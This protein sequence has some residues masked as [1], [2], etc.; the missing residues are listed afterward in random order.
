MHAL[1]RPGEVQPIPEHDRRPV[2]ILSRSLFRD[3]KRQGFSHNQIIALAAEL[4]GQ[5]TEELENPHPP[6]GSA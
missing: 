3:L 1:V 2:R 5:V 6:R 4:V